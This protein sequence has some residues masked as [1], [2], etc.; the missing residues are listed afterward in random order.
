VGKIVLPA[1]KFNRLCMSQ[2]VGT[3]VFVSLAFPPSV[4]YTFEKVFK[5]KTLQTDLTPCYAEAACYADLDLHR[6][7]AHS[8]RNHSENK[9]EIRVVKA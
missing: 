4:K 9:E 5:E 1:G 6:R 7:I 3:I 8:I 2:R